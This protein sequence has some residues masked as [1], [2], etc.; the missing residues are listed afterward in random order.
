MGLKR[1]F[2]NTEKGRASLSLN[3]EPPVHESSTLSTDSASESVSKPDEKPSATDEDAAVTPQVDIA[4]D[5][6]PKAAQSK[7][8]DSSYSNCICGRDATKSKAIPLDLHVAPGDLGQQRGRNRFI[9]RVWPRAPDGEAIRDDYQERGKMT[10]N[11]CQIWGDTLYDLFM[12]TRIPGLHGLRTFTSGSLMRAHMLRLGELKAAAD[13]MDWAASEPEP[14]QLQPFDVG[15]LIRDAENRNKGKYDMDSVFNSLLPTLQA[16]LPYHLLPEKLVVHD[17]WNTLSISKAQRDADTPWSEKD[18]IVHT[19]VLS[20]S[21]AGEKKVQEDRAAAEKV[22]AERVEKEKDEWRVLNPSRTP[23]GNMSNNYAVHAKVPSRLPKPTSILE[24]HLYIRRADRAGTGNHSVVYT[25]QLELPRW[26][27]AEDVL[28]DK[29]WWAAFEK[30]MDERVAADTL[31]SDEEKTKT[32]ELKV[33]T[34]IVDPR[35]EVVLLEDEPHGKECRDAR[36]GPS[37]LKYDRGVCMERVVQQLQTTEFSGPT[38]YIYPKIEWQRPGVTP[39]CEHMRI[40]SSADG[41]GERPATARVRVCAKMSIQHDAHLAREAANYQAFPGWLFEHWSGYNVVRPLHDPT[42]CGA[43]VPQF[44]GYYKP[45][46]SCEEKYFS[47]LLLL[48]HCGKE[49][50]V[51]ELSEDERNEAA[52]L[53]FHLL[54]GGWTQGSIAPR[55][56]LVQPGPI[57]ESPL[58]RMTARPRKKCFRLIDFGRALELGESNRYVIDKDEVF[59]LFKLMHHSE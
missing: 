48:E 3:E 40:P 46:S 26:A 59:R 17:P 57:T 34:K 53:Y 31:L 52:A 55:N 41:D 10:S 50:E 51:E 37:D 6:E 7:K 35:A 4:T 25:A 9:F 19:Y 42:P 49:I 56:V 16:Q 20:L 1:G 45:E 15:T 13:E 33:V 39:T 38:A 28:C 29:C 36:N 22:E 24:A 30:E 23:E 32:P 5:A 43:V 21:P 11:E 8:F 54:D 27:L 18:D 44:Y 2:L 58:G 14:K 47:P 12:T